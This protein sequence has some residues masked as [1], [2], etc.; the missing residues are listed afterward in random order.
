MQF[1]DD[2]SL[3]G[4][5]KIS[6]AFWSPDHQLFAVTS[7]FQRLTEPPAR[8]TY[9]G[10]LFEHRVSLYRPPSRHPIAVLD[11]V[12]LPIR[13]IAF[14]PTKTVIA[15]GAGS[16]DGGCLFQGQLVLWDWAEGRLK[17]LRK[18]PETVEVEFTDTGDDIE[19]L[20]RPWSEDLGEGQSRDSFNEYYRLYLKGILNR[21]WGTAIEEDVRQQIGNASP[22]T[23][24]DRTG[25]V[26]SRLP[27]EDPIEE[28]RSA[29]HLARLRQRSPVWDVA[30]LDSKSIGFVHK[31]CLL[32]IT[33]LQGEIQQSFQGEGY[34]VQIYRSPKPLVYVVRVDEHTKHFWENRN[35]ILMQLDS[36]NLGERAS[37]PGS[38]TFSVS[39]DDIVLGRRDRSFQSERN[40][41]PLDIILSVRSNELLKYDLGHYDVFNHFLRVDGAPFL[42]FV[43]GTPPSSHQNKY[44]CTVG[45]EGHVER[46]WPLLEGRGDHASHAMECC[47]C[48]IE[49]SQGRGMIVSGRHYD[50]QSFA[51]HGFIYRK[52]LSGQE[53]WR[54]PMTA[55][56]TSIKFASSVGVV[57]AAL[58]DGTILVL[59]GTDGAILNREPFRSDGY[60]S[61]V[62]SLDVDDANIAFGTIDGRC[63]WM[64]LLQLTK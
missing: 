33:D 24:F 20:V 55:G 47:F 36:G 35:A 2:I 9:G 31:D 26:A 43:Q 17:S 39:R 34:G 51:Y 16:Y 19:A 42:F 41:D 25:I 63:G 58:L 1:I 3:P 62:Y 45:T 11:K 12:V 13:D 44:L 10:H 49:D 5:G 4:L 50:P 57:V 37:I 40:S 48:F 23:K 38:Y 22:V 8:A 14:H 46:L 28:V 15:V 56:A 21:E 32:E 64:P 18:I 61:I 27:I 60:A 52:N 30:I 54:H 59:R 53:L 7:D 29:F 6:G